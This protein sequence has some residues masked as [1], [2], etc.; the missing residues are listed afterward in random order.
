M[1]A[2]GENYPVANVRYFANIIG[3]M[4]MRVIWHVYCFISIHV[5]TLKFRKMH[6]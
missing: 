4:G 2:L 3:M 5:V 6:S 1:Q